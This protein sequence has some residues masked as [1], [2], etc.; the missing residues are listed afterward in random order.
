MVITSSTLFAN[1]TVLPSAHCFKA[2]W[3]PDEECG[4]INGSVQ[5]KFIVFVERIMLLSASCLKLCV[6]ALLV[7]DVPEVKKTLAIFPGSAAW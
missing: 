4:V 2:D 3:Y 5:G 7:P 1:A 6:M